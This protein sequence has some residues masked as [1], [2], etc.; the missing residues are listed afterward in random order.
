MF[1]SVCRGSAKAFLWNCLRACAAEAP[2]N[3]APTCSKRGT[4]APLSLLST[5]RARHARSAAGV[6]GG[7]LPPQPAYIVQVPL[8]LLANLA[9]S[10]SC[11]L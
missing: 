11:R 9:S 4:K 2:L 8:P 7:A 6:P 1:L 3:T 10:S 5:P